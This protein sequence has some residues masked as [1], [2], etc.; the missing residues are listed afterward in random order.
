MN[1]KAT[2][3]NIV[4]AIISNA[5]EW[6]PISTIDVA[7][8]VLVDL[9]IVHGPWHY[10]RTDVEWCARVAQYA[11]AKHWRYPPAPPTLKETTKRVSDEAL[12][13]ILSSTCPTNSALQW[14]KQWELAQDLQVERAKTAILEAE[15]RRIC[16][17]PGN[18]KDKK[19]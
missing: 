15:N 1:K 5:S 2:W 17:L 6:R 11:H 16:A 9:W 19:G 10:R 14:H 8:G 3:Q 4:D 13:E 18:T 12:A 7:D